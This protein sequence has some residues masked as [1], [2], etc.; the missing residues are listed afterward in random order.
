MAF[1]APTAGRF[2][3]NIARAVP[4]RP[5][6]LS[7]HCAVPLRRVAVAVMV[8]PSLAIAPRPPS[9]SICHRAVHRRPSS[10]CSRSIAAA[11]APSLADE[12]PPRRTS[13]SRSRRPCL[14][15]TP[16]TRHAPPRPLV[17]MV[18]ALPLLTPPPSI[19]RCLSLRHR[20]SF[21]VIFRVVVSFG[22]A[23]IT[24]HVYVD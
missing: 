13:P 19:C 6:S 21:E 17:R 8:A 3:I 22:V 1:I 11:L 15:T 14:L 23:R 18:V 20:L 2:D 7:H 5:L 4:R 9:P 12:E 16:A 10:L 24:F